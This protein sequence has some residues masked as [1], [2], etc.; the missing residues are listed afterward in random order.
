MCRYESCIQSPLRILMLAT[1]LRR[2]PPCPFRSFR[3][4]SW[5]ASSGA[6]KPLT[7]MFLKGVELVNA[8]GGKKA[9]EECLSGKMVALY[10]SGRWCPNCR[11]FQPALNAF[12][13]EV[14]AEKKQLEIVFVGSDACAEDQLAHLKDHQGNWWMIPFEHESRNEL[15]RK[16]GVCAAKE[17]QQVGVTDRKNG[18]P[19]LV[20]VQ[21]NGDVVDLEG[22]DKVEMKGKKAFESWSPSYQF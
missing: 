1:I 11:D 9:A 16:Y 3:K 4:S 15:K 22:A 2:Y 21:H 10:F 12:Y 14:N 13:D 7:T 5:R 19:S 17:Q 18:I 6:L 20:I 8:Q